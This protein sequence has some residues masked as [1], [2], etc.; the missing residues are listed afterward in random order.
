MR[1][2]GEIS[3]SIYLVHWPV[4]T[5]LALLVGAVHGTPLAAKGSKLEALA[6]L[7]V[8]LPAILGLATLTY[9]YIEVPSRRWLTRRM[10]S[11][12]GAVA[13]VRIPAAAE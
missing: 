6:L 7:G 9:R 1:W 11:R 12:L 3:Y 10:P 13:P 5:A 4:F 8:A 2:L